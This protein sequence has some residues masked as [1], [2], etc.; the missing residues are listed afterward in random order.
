MKKY[1]GIA[2]AL[3]LLIVPA[4][5]LT[6]QSGIIYPQ[7]AAIGNTTPTDLITEGRGFIVTNDSASGNLSAMFLDNRAVNGATDIPYDAAGH[8]FTSPGTANQSAAYRGFYWPTIGG[9]DYMRATPY[10]D[11]T[12]AGTGVDQFGIG[13]GNLSAGYVNSAQL[14][15]GGLYLTSASFD[16]NSAKYVPGSAGQ[17]ASIDKYGNAAFGTN[18]PI[19]I[20]GYTVMTLNGSTGGLLGLQSS[21]TTYGEVYA[22]VGALNLD[23]VGGAPMLFHSGGTLKMS[24]DTA[25]HTDV[26]IVAS[27]LNATP[28]G[29]HA[30]CWDPG[31]SQITISGSNVCP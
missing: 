9:F 19:T 28:S 20:G 16:I 1:L 10:S 5:A 3:A 6:L 30:L 26:P 13:V 15:Q 7:Q 11:G 4:I 21:G 29:S 27:G 12:S 22:S 25:I 23:A 2:A 8:N 18:V 17:Y 14:T 31:S 24:I